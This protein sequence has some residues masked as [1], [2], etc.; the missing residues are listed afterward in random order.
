MQVAQPA[1]GAQ[2]VLQP[3]DG[4]GQPML[5]LLPNFS[6][7]QLALMIFVLPIALGVSPTAFRDA[8]KFCANEST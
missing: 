1:A 8:V 4:T 5:D 2:P 3:I 7:S 6:A